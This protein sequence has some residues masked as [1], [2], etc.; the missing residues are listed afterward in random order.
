MGGNFCVPLVC[1]EVVGALNK[2]I[3]DILKYA[4]VNLPSLGQALGWYHPVHSGIQQ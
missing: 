2:S 4:K 1:A 3:W